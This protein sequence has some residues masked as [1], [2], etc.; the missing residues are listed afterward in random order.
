MKRACAR[1][2][3]FTIVE[4][5]IVIVVIAILAAISIV[6][7][8]EVQGKA[9]DSARLQ[10]MKT[11]RQA[12]EVYTTQIGR[13]PSSSFQ[14]DT[15][16][17]WEA[18]S[19]E[20]AGQFL[21]PLVDDGIMSSVPIDPV[22]NAVAAGSMSATRAA[23]AIPMSTLRMR[24]A[25]LAVPQTGVGFMSSVYCEQRAMAPTLI[26]KALVLVAAVEIDKLSSP[27]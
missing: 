16:H 8:N 14:G 25:I 5:L 7:Y 11:I 1:G 9:R 12:I 26:P 20:P 23:G 27:G 22:N 6:A 17:G 18:S 24:Q 2:L 15:L 21:R 19:L 13:V 3:G 10:D 4:L